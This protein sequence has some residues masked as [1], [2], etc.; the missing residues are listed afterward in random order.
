MND[1]IRRFT[2][3]RIPGCGTMVRLLLAVL[4]LGL[5]PAHGAGQDRPPP[6]A[7]ALVDQGLALG[8]N[9]DAEAAL[10]SQAIERAPG[11][12]SA[13]FNLAFVR[14][15]QGR[16]QEAMESY[17]QCLEYDPARHD[18]HR[19]LALCILAVY[20]DAALYEARHHLNAAVELQ[21]GLPPDQRPA[22]LPE[23]EQSLLK[24]EERITETLRP[25]VHDCPSRETIVARLGRAVTRGGQGVYEGPRIAVTLFDSN[26]YTL[27][28]GNIACLRELALALHSPEL[29]PHGFV[30]EGHADGRAP[31]SSNDVLARKRADAVQDWLV[32]AGGVDPVRLEAQSY[33]EDRPIFPNN[34][35]D[36]YRKNRRIEIARRYAP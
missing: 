3:S 8:D 20:K 15:A 2:G 23:Q 35:W 6:E 25:E 19:N 9:S 14:H 29:A 5:T 18:A 13:H 28:A 26:H 7:Q 11:F 16:F 32:R 31:V 4:L 30:I 24:L 34:G 12:A 10:Y 33:G 21:Y 17:R 22:D 36:N 1:F 27:T